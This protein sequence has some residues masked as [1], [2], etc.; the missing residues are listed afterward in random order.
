MTSTALALWTPDWTPLTPAEL[1]GDA[2]VV[3]LVG[4]GGKTSLLHTLSGALAASGR[5]VVATTTTKMGMV[6][7]PA[8]DLDEAQA[9]LRSRGW[10]LAGIQQVQ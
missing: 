1:V 4:A 7:D 2:R 10:V 8:T 6:D 9:R 5:R 3:T